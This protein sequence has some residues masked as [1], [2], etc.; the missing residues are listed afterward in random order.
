MRPSSQ[1]GG[2]IRQLFPRDATSASDERQEFF[3]KKILRRKV[4]RLCRFAG[5]PQKHRV[6]TIFS[7]RNRNYAA[8]SRARSERNYAWKTF[9]WGWRGRG[10]K[11]GEFKKWHSS[12]EINL[13]P[14]VLAIRKTPRSFSRASSPPLRPEDN[15]RMRRAENEIRWH[16]PGGNVTTRT[17]DSPKVPKNYVAV[18]MHLQ[19]AGLCSELKGF[20]E[21]VTR[22]V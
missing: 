2:K 9:F 10:G 22:Y 16:R 20:R 19:A 13:G 6:A 12:P 14:H 8:A 15:E 18:E 7:A 1:H 5:A 21:K 4:G 17:R 11:H 3:L